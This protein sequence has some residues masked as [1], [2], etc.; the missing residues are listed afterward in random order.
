MGMPRWRSAPSAFFVSRPAILRV[1]QIYRNQE[2][3][4]LVPAAHERFR[5]GRADAERRVARRADAQCDDARRAHD[6][7]SCETRRVRMTRRG[8]CLHM[9]SAVSVTTV[10]SHGSANF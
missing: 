1:A 10:A 4:V 7:Q 8:R 9:H 5:V 2:L 6:R 3:T